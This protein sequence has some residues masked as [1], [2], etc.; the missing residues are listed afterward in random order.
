M[1]QVQRQMLSQHQ[2]IRT[3]PKSLSKAQ[4]KCPYKTWTTLPFE[5]IP[6]LKKMPV[7]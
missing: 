1:T 3:A 5:G 7:E 6:V 4:H 2:L